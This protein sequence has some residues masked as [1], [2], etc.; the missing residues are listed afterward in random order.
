MPQLTRTEQRRLKNLRK[1][2]TAKGREA[3]LQPERIDELLLLTQSDDP[4]VRC[5]AAKNLCPCHVQANHPQIWDRLIEMAHDPDPHVRMTILH[6][7]ADGSPREREQE[8]V[9]ALENLYNDDN[10]KVRKQIR[11]LLAQYRRTGKLNI[12]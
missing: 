8:I 5:E 3:R 7:L 2:P 12:L 1:L 10:L 11:Y 9:Q 4:D 6:T